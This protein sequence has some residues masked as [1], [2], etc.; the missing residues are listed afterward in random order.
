LSLFYAWK[1]RPAGLAYS[2][3]G[4]II[5][6][7]YGVTTWDLIGLVLFSVV[8]YVFYNMVK[9]CLDHGLTPGYTLDIFAINLAS[10]FIISFTRYGWWVYSVVP[11]YLLY[12]LGG[13]AWGYITNINNKQAAEEEKQ[14]DPKEAKRLEKQ[15]KKE[16]RP[17]VKYVR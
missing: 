4:E 3:E 11:G 2:D 9:N 12:K 10:Q 15:K 16:E 14:I 17:K 13:Y 7:Y 8:S 6:E 1:W 5:G